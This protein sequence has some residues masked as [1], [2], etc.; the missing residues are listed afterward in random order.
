[1]AELRQN[2]WVLDEWYDQDVAGN[3]S[4][5]ASGDAGNLFS[6][7]YNNGGDLGQNNRTKYSSP[8]QIPGSWTDVGGVKSDGTL[9]SWGYN[10]IG[11]LGQNDLVH[12]SSP[13]QIGAGTD[14]YEAYGLI[15]N[16][17]TEKECLAIKTNGTLWAWGYNH[18]GQFGFNNVTSY[19]SPI[20]IGS[21]TDWVQANGLY[22]ANMALLKDTTP[23]D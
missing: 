13:V 20:Q 23:D 14:W 19:S 15:D 11:G 1:M 12:R 21:E 16:A 3:V 4:Y 5:S 17:N 8:V 9:W 18:H 7:G 2:T 6:M 10:G 22:N